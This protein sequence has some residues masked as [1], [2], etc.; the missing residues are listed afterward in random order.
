MLGTV[1]I[2]SLIMSIYLFC[3]TIATS[4]LG[5]ACTN[6]VSA[7][8][9]KNNFY[10]AFKAVRTCCFFSIL[11]GIGS[12]LLVFSFSD[13]I[14]SVWLDNSISNIP[15]CLIAIGLPFIS[16]SSVLNG[17][18]C[19]IRKSYRNAFTQIFELFVK[20]ISTILLLKFYVSNGVESI[21]TCLILADV[22]SE[23]CSCFLAVFLY[24]LD[25]RKFPT[26]KS[27]RMNFKKRIFQIAFPV[28]ITSYIRSG[29]NTLK[30]FIIPMQLLAFGFPYSMALSEYG[31][32]SGM[33]MPL[34][35]FPNIF[36]TSFSGLLIPEFSSFS[37]NGNKK[38][39]VEICHIVFRIASV[40]SIFVASIFICFSHEI[41]FLVFQN[42][43]CANYIFVL[44]FLILLIYLDNIIDSMLKGLNKQF[45][46]MICNILDLV[47][48][49][50]ALYFLLPVFGMGGYI[51]ATFISEFFNFVVSYFQ[52]YKSIGF[53]L[54]FKEVLFIPVICAILSYLLLCCL[55]IYISSFIVS[56]LLF[57]V[58]FWGF[59][60]CIR[61][62]SY[63]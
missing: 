9:A 63:N 60:F 31:K 34:I 22:I 18:F 11:L 33:T 1:G 14:A 38:R 7:Q 39:L 25:K 46:V 12:G 44:S 45:G 47:I 6:L 42:L 26:F 4:G 13:L 41:S 16:I 36:I 8:F 62:F 59:Y 21:C 57:T 17:Y 32:I 27:E 54:H 23:I 19:A 35:T 61:S 58:S 30:Q 50:C 10:Q 2:F 28:S 43:E 52:L 37:A 49:I 56:V 3:V 5:L 20:I 53:K 15:I 40:F 29:L 55:A 24:K 48:T 51:F